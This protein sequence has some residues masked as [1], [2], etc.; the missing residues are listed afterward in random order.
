MTQRLRKCFFIL[1]INYIN[2][3]HDVETSLYSLMGLNSLL[4]TVL[5]ASVFF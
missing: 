4:C 1:E 5:L 3:F 2:K